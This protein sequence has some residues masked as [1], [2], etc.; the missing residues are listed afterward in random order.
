[1]CNGCPYFLLTTLKLIDRYGILTYI[2]INHWHLDQMLQKLNPLVL[3]SQNQGSVVFFVN[4][5]YVELRV[6]TEEGFEKVGVA[7]Y[8]EL[9]DDASTLLFEL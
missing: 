7:I 3:D 2:D 5:I 1:M 4:H 6:Y 8:G 9:V